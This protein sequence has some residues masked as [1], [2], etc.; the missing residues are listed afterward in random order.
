[1]DCNQ[2]GEFGT[3]GKELALNFTC[4]HKRCVHDHGVKRQSVQL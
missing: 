2:T 1:M 3:G 4:D